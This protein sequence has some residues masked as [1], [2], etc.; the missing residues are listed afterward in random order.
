M[1]PTILFFIICFSLATGNCFSQSFLNGDF[2][3]NSSI[4]CDYNLTDSVFNTKI[5]NVKAFGKAQTSTGYLGET[6]LLTWGCYVNPMNG[7]WCIGLAS[8]SASTS[9]AIVIE[10]TNNLIPGK[11]Y[12]LSFSIYGEIGFADSLGIIEIG[13]T[14]SDT[15]FGVFIDSFI[16]YENSWKPIS[17]IFTASQ[18]SQFISVRNK[19]KIYSW[20]LVDNFE[21]KPITTAVS[22]ELWKSNAIIYPNPAQNFVIVDFIKSISTGFA[23]L[24]S[25]SGQLLHKIEI[26]NCSEVTFDL[27]KIPTGVYFIKIESLETNEVLKFIKE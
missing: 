21:I 4:D 23:S 10:L 5:S 2:E 17:T 27:S 13:E 19:P 6:D 12:E 3:I 20:T 8:D 15:S 16:P 14:L 22:E 9:D 24:A 7:D 18:S 25:S 1:K 11:E 26:A